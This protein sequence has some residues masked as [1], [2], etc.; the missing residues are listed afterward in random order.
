MR[1]I[2]DIPKNKI[3]EL[4]EISKKNNISRAALIRKAIS[5][6]L[7]NRSNEG[8]D[9]AFGIWKNVDGLEYQKNIRSEW[10]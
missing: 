7:S 6:F 3:D 5:E 10:D 1:T 4:D 8:S 2:V 9:E